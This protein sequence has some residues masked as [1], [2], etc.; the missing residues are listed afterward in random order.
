MSAKLSHAWAHE[1]SVSYVHIL[2]IPCAIV[3]TP[4]FTFSR[5]PFHILLCK[6]SNTYM[7]S[8]SQYCAKMK[9]IHSS[10]KVAVV[11]QGFTN[12]SPKYSRRCL[13]FMGPGFGTYCISAFWHLRFCDCSLILWMFMYPSNSTAIQSCQLK[14]SVFCGVCLCSALLQICSSSK[15]III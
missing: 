10:G 12:P 13:N 7:K 6:V 14:Y 1:G 15:P 8:V 4:F 3:W 9:I 11:V 2:F 5:I